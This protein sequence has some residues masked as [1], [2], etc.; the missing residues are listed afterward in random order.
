METTWL[1]DALFAGMTANA[2]KLGTVLTRGWF[3]MR[4]AGCSVLYR[5]DSMET[6][7]FANILTVAEGGAGLISPPS[8][9]PHSS[10]SMYFYVVRRVNNCGQQER[11]LAAAVKVAIDAEGNLAAAE[12]NSIF[13]AK[14]EQAAGN[15]VRL[16]WFYCPLEQ[17]SEPACFKI[18]YDSGTGQVDYQNAIATISYRGR[19]FYNYQSD[20]LE[21]GRYLFAIKTEDS[22]GVENGSWAQVAVQTVN[23]SPD[24]AEILSAG[25]I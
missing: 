25:G 6:I 5:G 4:V 17:E 13:D 12:P 8:Y 9:V 16:V 1:K 15:K 7:D 2:F 3:W 10:N 18:Y 23:E 19:G 11:T 24:A 21:E 22:E 20:A 14:I